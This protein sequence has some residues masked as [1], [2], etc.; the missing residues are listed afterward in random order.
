MERV[1]LAL[2]M[3]LVAMRAALGSKE[4][5]LGLPRLSLPLL[6]HSA[7]ALQQGTN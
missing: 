1:D 3:L 6:Q 2:P 5:I 7:T 4:E